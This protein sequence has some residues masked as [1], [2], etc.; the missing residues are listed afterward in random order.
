[1]NSFKRYFRILFSVYCLMFLSGCTVRTYSVAK[2]RIDQDMTGNQGYLSGSAPAGSQQPKKFTKRATKVVEIELR[3]PFKFERLKEP[4][5]PMEEEQKSASSEVTSGYLGAETAP[6]GQPEEIS[7][8]AAPEPQF[9]A[10]TVQKDDTLQKISSKF[11]GTTKKWMKIFK[12]NEDVLKSPDKLRPGQTI[13]I[14]K[15]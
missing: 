14:P 12:A 15:E 10:Y 8:G 6:S 9:E 7:S 2:D 5:K 3:S 4:P 1:M 11:F 13:K